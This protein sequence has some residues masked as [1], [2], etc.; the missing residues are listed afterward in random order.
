MAGCTAM[1][2]DFGGCVWCVPCSGV[3]SC[4]TCPG[5]KRKKIVRAVWKTVRR[6]N[7][8]P[9]GPTSSETLIGEHKSG[10]GNRGAPPLL[11][12][13]EAETRSNMVAYTPPRFSMR[14]LHNPQQHR[15][16]LSHSLH[17]P[18][19]GL[20]PDPQ[21]NPRRQTCARKS[22]IGT[23]ACRT[24]RAFSH[25]DVTEGSRICWEAQYD[26]YPA[27]VSLFALCDAMDPMCLVVYSSVEYRVF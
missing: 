3:G 4:L 20:I 13:R 16:I 15:A 23:K 11:F 5:R 27:A 8:S 19:Y 14:Q 17:H 22:L 1:L 24:E 18:V 12:S 25:V 2:S 7:T 10:Q 9:S 21:L 26:S 6:R